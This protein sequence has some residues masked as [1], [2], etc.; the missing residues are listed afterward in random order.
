MDMSDRWVC[1][2]CSTRN[3]GVN[4]SCQGCGQVRGI[5]PP[6]EIPD[7]SESDSAP[8]PAPPTRSSRFRIPVWIRLA[9]IPI[10]LVFFVIPFFTDARRDGLGNITRGGE[11]SV[12]DLQVGDCFDIPD[13][14]AAEIESV[15]ALPCAEPHDYEVF[16]IRDLAPG[17]FPTEAEF[18]VF[19]ESHCIAAFEAY[20]DRDYASS[21]IWVEMMVP[22]TQGW[23]DGD[24]AIT[25]F[26]YEPESKLTGSARGSG[27]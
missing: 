4:Y 10:A 18:D 26:L 27:R 23:S 9:W 6:T 15:E 5:A 13:E 21:A 16:A 24:R 17:A 25:C 19:L 8:P 14:D 22:T 1:P 12:H 3:E 11:L 20:V 2:Q 7:T